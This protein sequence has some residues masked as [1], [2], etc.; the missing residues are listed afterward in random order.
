MSVYVDSS[1]SFILFR[2]YLFL[3][4]EWIALMGL[5][6]VPLLALGW[7]QKQLLCGEMSLA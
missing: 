1:T 6:R 4:T 5:V 2:M 7:V 3:L